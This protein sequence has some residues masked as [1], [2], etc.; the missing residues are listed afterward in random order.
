MSAS[1]ATN[2]P[3]R[4]DEWPKSVPRASTGELMYIATSGVCQA[5][6]A[7]QVLP[8]FAMVSRRVP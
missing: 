8:D 5:S 7:A 6:V 1:I 4:F 3:L 2:C